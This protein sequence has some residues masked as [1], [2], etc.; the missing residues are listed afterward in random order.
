MARGLL[1]SQGRWQE[2]LDDLRALAARRRPAEYLV[3][4][5]RKS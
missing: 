5:G 4:L 2:L 3:V 1:E